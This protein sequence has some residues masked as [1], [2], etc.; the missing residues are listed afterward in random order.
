MDIIQI[1][2]KWLT[3]ISRSS[4][5]KDLQVIRSC[6]KLGSDSSISFTIRDDSFLQSYNKQFRGTDSPTDVLSFDS[7]E[8]DPDTG[9][10]H[11]GD[12]LI[13]YDRVISQAKKS[14]HSN[15]T[16]LMLLIVHGVLHLLKYDHATIKDRATMWKKQNEVLAALGITGI[17]TSSYD[18]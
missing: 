18:E 11:L 10:E 15:Y 4:L 1:Q 6:L 12:I 8:I 16:E 2:K 9:F 13:S 3:Q 5:Q 7:G 14:G 17:D